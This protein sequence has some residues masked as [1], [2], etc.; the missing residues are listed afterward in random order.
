[1]TN[2]RGYAESLAASVIVACFSML[3]IW[4]PAGS[5][6]VRDAGIPWLKVA[7]LRPFTMVGGSFSKLS[8]TPRAHGRKRL[9]IL[10]AGE[11]SGNG[12]HG[13]CRR[14]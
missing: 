6:S 14:V 3:G 7:C 2:L 12:W 11:A 8:A 10:N 4:P 9:V 13:G 5:Y 1:M